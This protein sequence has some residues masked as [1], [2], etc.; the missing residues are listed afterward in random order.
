M[1]QQQI[2]IIFFGD[3]ICVGQFVSIH[4]GW[5]TQISSRLAALDSPEAQ[6]VVMNASANGRTTE[7]FWPRPRPSG[8]RP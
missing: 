6:V 1:A 3:S 5:V 8:W 4:E 7:R 2:K